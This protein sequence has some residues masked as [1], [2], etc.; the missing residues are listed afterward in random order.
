LISII[1][2]IYIP[3]LFD[4]YQTNNSGDSSKFTEEHSK[5]SEE[6]SD[7]P[8]ESSAFFEDPQNFLR[9]VILRIF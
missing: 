8:E 5:F 9:I 1:S 4:G 7:F 2:Y 6:P 3:E